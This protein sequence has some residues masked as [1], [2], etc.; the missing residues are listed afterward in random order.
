MMRNLLRSDPRAIRLMIG[1]SRSAA[2]LRTYC[3]VTA[4]SSMTTPAALA[5]AFAA[6]VPTSSTDAAAARASTDTSSSRATSPP[7]KTSPS[8]V[9]Q[10]PCWLILAQIADRA[11]HEAADRRRVAGVHLA[12]DPAQVR[13]LH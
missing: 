8:R 2:R 3:G 5:P 9:E 13:L 7:A 4:A 1:N 6:A 11:G 12:V 10:R